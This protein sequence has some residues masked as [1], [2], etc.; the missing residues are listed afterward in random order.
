MFCCL[1]MAVTII[2][3]LIQSSSNFIPTYQSQNSLVET[4]SFVTDDYFV[5]LDENESVYNGAVDL[6]IGRIPASTDF[7]AELVVNKIRD[8]YSPE[9]LGNWRNV[10]CFIGDDEDGNRAYAKF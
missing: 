8:Y 4:Q 3:I 6:G 2:K 10:V 1:A 9:A 7:Q 5:I